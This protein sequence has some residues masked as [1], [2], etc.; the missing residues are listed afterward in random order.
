MVR[1]IAHYDGKVLVPSQPVDLPEGVP[2]QVTVQ[3]D[4]EGTS[5]D[6]ILALDGLGREVWGDI[7]PLEYQ[8]QE[9]EGWE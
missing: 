6:A 3:T 2:L 1:L 5:S 8:R 9:R 7:D 4:E